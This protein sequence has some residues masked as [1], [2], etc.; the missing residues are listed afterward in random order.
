MKVLV[1][2]CYGGFR[3]SDKAYERLIELGIPCLAWSGNGTE[4]RVIYK[5]EEHEQGLFG[6]YWDSW[7]SDSKNRTNPL[8]IQVVEELGV[9]A[10]AYISNIEVVEIPDYIDWTIGDYDGYETVEEVHRSW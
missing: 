10:S 7:T 8:V 3:L 9:E 6:R 1:N 5:R 4:V 2:R